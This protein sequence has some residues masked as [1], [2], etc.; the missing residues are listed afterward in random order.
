MIV[1]QHA[2]G[3]T[4]AINFHEVAPLGWHTAD[5][6]DKVTHSGRRPFKWLGQRFAT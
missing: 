4:Q 6:T 3:L 2:E 5:T 1:R